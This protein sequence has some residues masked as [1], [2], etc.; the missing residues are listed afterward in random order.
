MVHQHFT[1]AGNLTV[2][3][4]IRLGTEGL[5]SRRQA[6]RRGPRSSVCRATSG[7]RC[8][9]EAKVGRLS[10]G[11]RQRVEILKALYRD[12]RILI[13]DEPTA[14]LTPQE[15]EALFATLRKATAL[16]LS[17]IFI[18]HKLHEVMAIADRCV[19]LRHGK[20]VGEVDTH[21]TDKG[22]ACRADGRGRTGPAPGRGA[23]G[24]DR[25]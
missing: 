16:G 3:D 12:A 9:P 1:L 5:W 4:N 13:L 7:W 19:V 17:I 10:V 14:V 24:G 21:T 22:Q 15:A 25:C 20:V 8:I 18:S 23:C 2:L 11:E 6:G